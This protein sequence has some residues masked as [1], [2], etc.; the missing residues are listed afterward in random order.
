[1]KIDIPNEQIAKNII[2]GFFK[3]L[4]VSG[5]ADEL[6]EMLGDAAYPIFAKVSMETMQCKGAINSAIAERFFRVAKE[7]IDA[8]GEDSPYADQF[9][10]VVVENEFTLNEDDLGMAQLAAA[11]QKLDIRL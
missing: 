8:V 1:M 11:C 7:G 5:R 6:L 9:K 3:E 2:K 4:S 10:N